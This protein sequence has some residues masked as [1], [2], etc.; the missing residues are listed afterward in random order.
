MLP[1]TGHNSTLS[2][3]YQLHAQTAGR[4]Q[5]L[6]TAYTSGADMPSPLISLPAE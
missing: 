2:L 3:A 5:Q 1:A 4:D 6:P